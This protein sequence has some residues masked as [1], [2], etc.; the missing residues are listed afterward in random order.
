MRESRHAGHVYLSVKTLASTKALGIALLGL[1]AGG[2]SFSFS[3][4]GG[5]SQP[6]YPG[7]YGKTISK[8][9]YDDGRSTRGKPITKGASKSVDDRGSGN[10]PATR[11]DPPR[12]TKA[13][14]PPTR[15]PAPTRDPKADD[16]TSRRPSPVR[17][18]NPN[19]KDKPAERKPTARRPSTDKDKDTARTPT[20]RRPSTDKDKDTARKPTARRPSADKDKDTARKPSSTARRTDSTS[21]TRSGK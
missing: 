6:G 9:S 3:T 2:C 19:T 10:E 16:D 7:S 13:T 15:R 5:G 1:V 17:E 21:R 20:A 8:A 11:N 18:P 14:P 4:N 12:R